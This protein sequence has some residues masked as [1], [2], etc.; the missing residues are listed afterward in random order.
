M[1]EWFKDWFDTDEYLYVYRNRNEEDAGKLVN[2]ILNNISLADKAKVLDLAC[3]TGRHSILFAEKGYDVTSV[4]LSKNLLQIARCSA[5]EANVKINFIR[6]DLRQFSICTKFDLVLNLYT[7]FGYFDN[8]AENFG[9]INTAYNQ[10]NRAGYFVLDFLNCLYVEKNIVSESECSVP[11]GKIIQHRR[12]SGGRIK[13]KIII[14]KDGIKKEFSESVRMYCRDEL[15]NAISCA[16]FRIQKYFGSYNGKD[17][18][19]ENSPR[20]IIIAQK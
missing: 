8:D 19:L 15:F 4:D 12:I 1:G 14:E 6:S 17:F 10:L 3:G 16:G 9:I 5:Y 20:I 7:S 18:D 13:K 11:G 2:L